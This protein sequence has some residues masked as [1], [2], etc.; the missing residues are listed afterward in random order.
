MADGKRKGFGCL[1]FIALPFLFGGLALTGVGVHALLLYRASAGWVE[2]PARVE[3]VELVESRKSTA[4]EVT[5]TYSYDWKGAT[6]RST[7][8]GTQGGA[9]TDPVHAVRAAALESAKTSGT[10][11]P[12]LVDPS[13]PTEALLYRELRPSTLALLAA[14]LLFSLLTGALFFGALRWRRN[15]TWSLA[16]MEQYPAQPWRYERIWSDFRVASSARS[17]LVALWIAGLA[18]C[19]FATP[20]AVFF[21][22]GSEGRG[23]QIVSGFLLALAVL[24]VAFAVRN[25]LAWFRHGTAT[26]VLGELPLRPGSVV[27]AEVLWGAGTEP[28]SALVVLRCLRSKTR[29]QNSRERSS[30]LKEL[31]RDE[32]RIEA[33]AWTRRA[34][35]G[36]MPVTLRLPD[37]AQ[38]RADGTNPSTHW[39][40]DVT[41]LGKGIGARHRFDL[42]V[43]DATAAERNAAVAGA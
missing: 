23:G 24:I 31:H 2:V 13:D 26:L 15:E 3:Q 11:V 5:A 9:S 20:F 4:T 17:T 42:P 18:T 30:S 32:M 21:L 14:G 12:A 27:R 16:R 41:L 25:T 39:Y 19:L 34:D 38:E 40:L 8:V 36:A 7:R 29:W 1:A 6:H 43:F 10:T 28:Q 37:D 22:D 33:G 35:G